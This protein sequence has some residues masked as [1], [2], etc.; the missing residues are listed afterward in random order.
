M[1]KRQITCRRRPPERDV[2]VDIVVVVVVLV[3]VIDVTKSIESKTLM[4]S[5]RI[6]SLFSVIFK[7]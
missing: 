3:V 1:D 6:S 2:T 5:K 7:P 4:L